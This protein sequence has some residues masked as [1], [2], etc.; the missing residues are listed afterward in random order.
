MGAGRMDFP[1]FLPALPQP[2]RPRGFSCVFVL[3]DSRR[4][5]GIASGLRFLFALLPLHLPEAGGSKSKGETLAAAGASLSVSRQC[6][7]C[8]CLLPRLH[9]PVLEPSVAGGSPRRGLL[10]TL[11]RSVFL[12]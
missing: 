4:I 8:G 3:H 5:R 12:P 9:Q 6:H 11:S 10:G 2:R 7:Q 1:V